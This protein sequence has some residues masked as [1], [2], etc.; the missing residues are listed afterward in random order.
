MSSVGAAAP[1][2]AWRVLAIA[3]PIA[4]SNATVP[5]QGAV[6]TA[7]IGN[8]GEVSPLAA[9][10]LGAEILSLVFASLNFLQISSSGLSAQAIGRNDRKGVVSVLARAIMVALALALLILLLKPLIRIGGLALFEEGPET[11][12]LAGRYVD[13]RLWGAPAEL[14]NMALVGWFAG[15]EMPRRMVQH[16]IFTAFSN[17]GLSLFFVL[18]LGW[19]VAGVAAATVCASFAGLIYGL[20]LAKG[21]VAALTAASGAPSRAEILR[22][23]ALVSFF[24]LSGNIF[25]RTMLLVASLAW[26]ARLGSI[27]G[28]ATLAANVV[29]FQFFII[30]A[31]ALD[32]FAIASETLVGQTIGA[33]NRPQLVRAIRLTMVCSSLMALG[34]SLIFWL[35]SGPII[36]TLTNEPNVRQIARDYALWAAFVPLVGVISYQLD[37]IFV[38]ATRAR[39][40]RNSMIISTALYVPLSWFL[41]REFSNDGVWAAM[42]IWLLLRAA[43]LSLYL[44]RVLRQAELKPA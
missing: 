28:D 1:V 39:D 15:Q 2:T 31:F 10:G 21:R 24:T 35:L 17:I 29:L 40:M 43:T 14:A 25:I 44:P 13:I 34:L 19:G 36:D 3:A 32:G 37:G 26:M 7:I 23:E 6:D 12:V 16:Q 5:L 22:P 11:G 8:L 30:S 9:V 4:L 33:R 41:M 18:G 42:W 20:W 27:L 38:G